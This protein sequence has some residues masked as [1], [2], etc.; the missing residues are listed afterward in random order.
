MADKV[1][2]EI[3]SQRITALFANGDNLDRL[4]FGKQIRGLGFGFLGNVAVET[5]TQ[6]TFRRHYDQQMRLIRSRTGQKTRRAFATGRGCQTSHHS[7][8]TFGIRT[9]HFSCFLGAAQFSSRDHLH[10]FRDLAGRF[11]RRD[12]IFKDF[13]VSH[14]ASSFP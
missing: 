9:R 4:T 3:A 12:P 8:E 14:L 2:P 1:F 5:A 6:S 7:I 13:K 11:D 10:G